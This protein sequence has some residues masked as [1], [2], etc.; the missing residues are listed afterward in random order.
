[1]IALAVDVFHRPVSELGL[2]ESREIQLYEAEYRLRAQE[3]IDEQRAEEAK[4]QRE[5]LGKKQ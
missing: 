3:R 1:M 5:T 2:L 4:A